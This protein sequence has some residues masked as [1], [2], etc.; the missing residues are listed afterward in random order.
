[1]RLTDLTVREV[2]AALGSDNPAPGAGAAA[3][4]TVA[5]AAAVVAKVARLSPEWEDSAGAAAQACALSLRALELADTDARAYA[6][7]LKALDEPTEHV[8]VRLRDARLGTALGH[9]AESPLLLAGAAC[10]TAMLGALVA[11]EGEPRLRADALGA[12]ALASA[13]AHVAADLVAVNLTATDGDERVARARGF[14]AEAA[15]A[16]RSY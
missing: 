14:A 8:D 2:L 16:L 3:G 11:E 15:A 10:D 6:A 12:A 9:A 4:L 1:M 5:L 7:V 13:A